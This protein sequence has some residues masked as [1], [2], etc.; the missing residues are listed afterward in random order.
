MRACA[1]PP[2]SCSALAAWLRVRDRGPP[3]P[4][5]K[6]SSASAAIPGQPLKGA[7]RPSSTGK[8]VSS[9][10]RGTALAKL[11]LTG[12][13]RRELRHQPWTCPEGFPVADQADAGPAQA[14]RRSH[15]SGPSTTGRLPAHH[16]HRGGSRCAAD[17]GAQR[18]G[19]LPS[20]ARISPART[21]RGRGARPCSSSRADEGFNL[22]LGTPGQTIASARRNPSARLPWCANPRR[23]LQPST[24]SFELEKKVFQGRPPRPPVRIGGK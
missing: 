19:A 4:Q 14:P 21:A 3:P 6:S 8:Q 12:K 1:S 23:R 9:S 7:G 24:R 16:A 17:N 2:A 18:A 10:R 11:K 13:E 20:A 15:P 22:V 5:E